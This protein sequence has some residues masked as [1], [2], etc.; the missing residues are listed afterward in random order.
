MSADVAIEARGL[1]VLYADFQILWN[2]SFVAPRGKI[3]AILGPNGS[4]KSTLMNTLSGLVRA[5]SG[6]ISLGAQRIDRLLRQ[7]DLPP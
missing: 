2:V 4:G 1:D 5:R 6:E 7:R 3:V